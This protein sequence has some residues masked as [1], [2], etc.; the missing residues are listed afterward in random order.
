MHKQTY[1]VL[2]HLIRERLSV[3]PCCVVRGTTLKLEK[4][5]FVVY[6]MGDE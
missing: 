5:S 2:H 4:V 3:F 1:C 6:L